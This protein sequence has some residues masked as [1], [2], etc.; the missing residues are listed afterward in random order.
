MNVSEPSDVSSDAED[1]PEIQI[2]IA[3]TMSYKPAVSKA[4]A[5]AVIAD[6]V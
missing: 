6:S 2:H 4:G 1:L 5:V 3:R